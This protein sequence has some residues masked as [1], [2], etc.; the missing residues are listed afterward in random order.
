MDGKELWWC[1][2]GK[3]KGDVRKCTKTG[4]ADKQTDIGEKGML[5]TTGKVEEE[6]VLHL[7]QDTY[8]VKW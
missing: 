8:L 4:G 5:D 1:I 2:A 3:K 7:K 6:E